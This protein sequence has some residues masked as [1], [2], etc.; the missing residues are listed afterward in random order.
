M[1]SGAEVVNQNICVRVNMPQIRVYAYSLVHLRVTQ[2]CV[3][4]IHAPMY[5]P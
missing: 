5:I 4:A 2:A 3:S 1:G